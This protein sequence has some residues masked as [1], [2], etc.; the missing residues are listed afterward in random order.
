MSYTYCFPSEISLEAGEWIEI[1][2]IV[3]NLFLAYWIV[4]TVQDKINNKRVLKDHLINEIKDIRYEYRNFLNILYSNKSKPQEIVP[5]FK[6]MSIKIKDI[7]ELIS[8][9]H[10]IDKKILDSYKVELKKIITEFNEYIDN[11]NSNSEIILTPSSHLK[12]I[13]F[14]QKYNHIFND[15]I[16]QIND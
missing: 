6:L 15:I 1:A 13:K 3:V 9:S 14:E 12:L 8:K 2:S 7:I 11:Y 10:K 4:T 16:V 5:W